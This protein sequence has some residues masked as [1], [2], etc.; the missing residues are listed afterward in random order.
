MQARRLCF[1][2]L[3]YVYSHQKHLFH[4]FN[5]YSRTFFEPFPSGSGT[6]IQEV[7]AGGS[8]L[9]TNKQESTCH[10]LPFFHIGILLHP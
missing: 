1:K 3:P 9:S 4:P 7:R 6:V 2:A 10:P 5:Q 8:S